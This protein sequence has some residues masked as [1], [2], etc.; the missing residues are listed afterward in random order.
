MH[1]M[2]KMSGSLLSDN[3]SSTTWPGSRSSISA[4]A[5]IRRFTSTLIWRSGVFSRV[6]R[7]AQLAGGR[8][9]ATSP[10][11]T[12]VAARADIHGRRFVPSLVT[13]MIGQPTCCA[14]RF[15]QITVS[16]QVR[17]HRSLE[18]YFVDV[19]N[20]CKGVQ[21]MRELGV[22]RRSNQVAAG[23]RWPLRC[24]I[25]DYENTFIAIRARSRQR[26]LSL[27]SL[28]GYTSRCGI[29]TCCCSGSRGG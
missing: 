11:T 29:R 22:T 27:F 20:F 15:I 1:R 19:P 13:G 5:S 2:L 25:S 7:L 26:R 8:S 23:N 18:I 9:A 10:R 28:D 3:R 6:D 4:S 24:I 16:L 17:S 12:S 21:R 14:E